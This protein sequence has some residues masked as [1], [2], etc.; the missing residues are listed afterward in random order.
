MKLLYANF[1]TDEPMSK[2]VGMIGKDG[3]SVQ[4]LDDF[5]LDGLKQVNP[6]GDWKCKQTI[7]CVLFIE[8]EYHG[9]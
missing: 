2:S 5:T 9:N 1:H 3:A 8:F 6:K 4:V 7:L